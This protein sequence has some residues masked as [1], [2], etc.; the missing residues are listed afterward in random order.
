MSKWGFSIA[1]G[2]V[3]LFIASL[4]IVLLYGSVDKAP[5]FIKFLIGGGVPFFAAR[6]VYRY[7]KSK[8]SPSQTQESKQ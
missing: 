6:S 1:T 8:E 5:Y 7:F 4:V 2:L 3:A